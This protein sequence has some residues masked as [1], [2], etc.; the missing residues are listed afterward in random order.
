MISYNDYNTHAKIR[1]Y[2]RVINPTPRQ[3]SNLDAM[4]AIFHLVL[5]DNLKPIFKY[6]MLIW[7]SFYFLTVAKRK[8][9]LYWEWTRTFFRFFVSAKIYGWRTR[10][11][12]LYINAR[13]TTKPAQP[14][15]TQSFFNSLSIFFLCA[16]SQ[17]S[18]RGGT[19]GKRR[20]LEH[21]KI[22]ILC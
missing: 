18:S 4:S 7:K 3:Y 9:N 1:G 15:G 19:L 20:T 10:Y 17:K 14:R 12:R 16:P 8:K 13:Y 21:L 6:N 2:G 5:L 11:I 22:L